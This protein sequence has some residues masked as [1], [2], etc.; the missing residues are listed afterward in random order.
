MNGKIEYE[1][2]CIVP[3]EIDEDKIKEIICN[4]IAN[5]LILENSQNCTFVD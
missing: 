2:E 4:K 5:V 1:V 3:E